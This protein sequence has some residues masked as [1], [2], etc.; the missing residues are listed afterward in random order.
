MIATGRERK[1]KG[2]VKYSH[3]GSGWRWKRFVRGRDEFSFGGVAFE[4][5][6]EHTHM[7]LL[8]ISM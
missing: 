7:N 5:S 8:N 1:R 6:M 2:E 3:W 4:K